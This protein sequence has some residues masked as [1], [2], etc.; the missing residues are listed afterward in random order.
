MK[1]SVLRLCLAAAVVA[2]AVGTASAAPVVLP[3]SDLT[4]G[5]LNPAVRQGTIGRTICKSG[6]TR[7]VRPSTSYTNKLKQVQMVQYGETGSPSDYEEDH[8]I[9]LELGGA[10]RIPKNLWPEPHAQSKQS[11]PLETRLKRQVC[12]RLISLA[13][14]R[15]TIR[16]FKL[17]NG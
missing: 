5:A 10:P 15:T 2:A 3:N 14:A 8:F 16:A 1:A 4:P 13:R 12:K 9:P 17:A 6:W 7:T 11:D